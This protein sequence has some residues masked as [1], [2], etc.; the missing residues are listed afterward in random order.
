MDEVNDENTSDKTNKSNHYD[1][2]KAKM[3]TLC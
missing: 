3:S 2:L 1:K